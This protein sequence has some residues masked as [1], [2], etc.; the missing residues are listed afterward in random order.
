M[1]K[2]TARAITQGLTENG[3]KDTRAEHPWNCLSFER[4]D[5]P[6]VGV[7]V[8]GASDGPVYVCISYPDSYD[9][10]VNLLET[11]SV[12]DAIGAAKKAIELLAFVTS[13]QPVAA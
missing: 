11:D 2:E 4:F 8:W 13:K 9:G 10:S 1:N 3:F 5:N 6:R 7:S 12:E